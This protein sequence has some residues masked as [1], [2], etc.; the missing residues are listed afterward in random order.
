MTA[1]TPTRRTVPTP[2][3]V[4]AALASVLVPLNSTM[5]AVALSDVARDFDITKGRASV[6]VTV[7][8]AAMLLG[9]PLAGRLGDTVG[10]RRLAT[11]AVAGFGACSIGALLATT[12]PL[13]VA[14]RALQAAFAAALAPSVQAILRHVVPP[15]ERGRAFGVQ[16]SVTAIG[17]AMG[18]IVG[19]L[20]TA[21]G[22][23]RAIFAVNLPIVAVVLVSLRRHVTADV[24]RTARGRRT[25]GRAGGRIAGAVFVAACATQ[26]LTA[27]AQ[28]ALLL[29]VPIV[30]DARGWGAAAIG[31][32]L[33][34]LTI[35]MVVTGPPG[36]RLGDAFGRRAPVVAGLVVALVPV[37]CAAAAGDGAASWLVLVTVLV[38]GLG[39]GVVMPGVTTA[40]MDA[41]PEARVGAAAGVLS[42]SRYVG[43]IVATLV[44]AGLVDD[45]GAGLSSML[46]ICAIALGAGLVAASRLPGPQRASI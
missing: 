20:A 28:Y 17:A 18:P 25:T 24:D 42:A 29:A 5:L 43:S 44:L 4:G 10:V 6:L 2:T 12:F 40:G 39:L 41:A 1:A 33:G 36:G 14:M 15:D 9:Q 38:F 35:G 3:I 32:G 16:S 27:F 11:I 45:D 31:A 19:G 8:L 23:W 30:L 46:V 13:L 34:L 21:A 26:A 7:Y 22:G 37:A